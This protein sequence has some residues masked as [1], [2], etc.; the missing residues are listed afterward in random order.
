MNYT[1][2]FSDYWNFKNTVQLSTE[3]G[4]SVQQIKLITGVLFYE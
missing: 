1:F 4:L 2:E 3:L